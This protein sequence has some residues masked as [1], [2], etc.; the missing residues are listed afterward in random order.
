[1]PAVSL[2]ITLKV[3]LLCIGQL[4]S[5]PVTTHTVSHGELSMGRKKYEYE[6][7]TITY[8]N[9]FIIVIIVF[10]SVGQIGHWSREH[11]EHIPKGT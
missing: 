10:Y 5:R 11:K 7:S 2:K 1:M 6:F 8:A 9:E 3:E 4:F